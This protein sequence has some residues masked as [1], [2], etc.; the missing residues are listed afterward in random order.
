MSSGRLVDQAE[1]DLRKVGQEG[2]R[3]QSRG[4]AWE[5][6]SQELG[7]MATCTGHHTAGWPWLCSH[8][9]VVAAAWSPAAGRVGERPRGRGEV[10][11][12]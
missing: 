1:G 8:R 5:V 9:G 10:L 11:T 4:V 2:E 7:P 6:K 3:W 12:F